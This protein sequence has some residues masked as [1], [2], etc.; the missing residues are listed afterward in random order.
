MSVSNNHFVI[1]L[2]N[3]GFLSDKLIT[4]LSCIKIQMWTFYFATSLMLT[5]C[6]TEGM[7]TVRIEQNMSVN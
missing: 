4:F 5:F 3:M 6:R 7:G 2:E 1:Y